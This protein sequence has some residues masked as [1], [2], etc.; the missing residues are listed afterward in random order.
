ME[1]L[2]GPDRLG[3]FNSEPTRRVGRDVG[4]AEIDRFFRQLA[5]N[6]RRNEDAFKEGAQDFESI[7]F[8]KG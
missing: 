8:E 7:R 2:E 3:R 4:D 6:F 5:M 1:T